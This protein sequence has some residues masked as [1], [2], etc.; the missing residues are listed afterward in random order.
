MDGRLVHVED[1]LGYLGAQEL[2]HEVLLLFPDLAGAVELVDTVQVNDSHLD[3]VADVAHSEC[4][5]GDPYLKPAEDVVASFFEW[6]AC[7]KLE[8]GVRAQLSF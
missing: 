3:F 4:G 7:M 6:E 8:H 5:A 2:H 1:L